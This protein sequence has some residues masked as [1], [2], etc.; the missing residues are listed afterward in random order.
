MPATVP[1]QQLHRPNG[2]GRGFNL[3]FRLSAAAA[4]APGD[5]ES[6]SEAAASAEPRARCLRAPRP[7]ADARLGMTQAPTLW[8]QSRSQPTGRLRGWHVTSHGH[9]PGLR[10]RHCRR[11]HWQIES[12]AVGQEP[13][14][15]EVEFTVTV[16]KLAAKL[17]PALDP[18]GPGR[19]AR[20]PTGMVK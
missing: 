13:G 14:G 9:G 12:A 16:T 3:K 1:G 19:A 11:G 2:P 10:P 4:S 7:A 20:S 8:P 15:I 6:D 18:D 17:P 5:T